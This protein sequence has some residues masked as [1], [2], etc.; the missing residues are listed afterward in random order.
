[1]SFWDQ[2]GGIT[3][4][5]D[6]AEPRTPEEQQA[7]D[8]ECRRLS[9]YYYAACPFCARVRNAIRRMG[10]TIE[11]R[12]THHSQAYGDELVHGGGMSQVPCL[13]IDHED[14]TTQWMYESNDIINY[15]RER[16]QPQG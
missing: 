2:I 16:F 4:K 6:G 8:V 12:N 1:M 7:V 11:E 14:G 13:R 5:S 3:G 10:L 9:L 15:L